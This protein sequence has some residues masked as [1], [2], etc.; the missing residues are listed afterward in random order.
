MKNALVP[1][2]GSPAA[3]RALT[4]ALAELGSG[5]DRQVH[6][7]NVQTPLVH[8]WPGR[9]VSPDMIEAEQVREGASLLEPAQAQALAAGI[10]CVPHVRLGAAAAEQIA[11]CAAEQG[12]DAIVM[13]TRGMGAVAGLVLGSVAQKVVHLAP[14]PVTLVK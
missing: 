1:I 8:P 3:L 6:L 13:G 11:G 4:H 12:C 14:V 5:A 10:R 2:D 9:L 7:L